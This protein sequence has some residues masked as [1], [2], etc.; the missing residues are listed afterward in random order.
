M[1]TRPRTALQSTRWL[2]GL[3]VPVGQVYIVAYLDVDESRSQSPASGDLGVGLSS[4][5]SS[6]EL[7][8]TTPATFDI[9]MN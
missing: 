9:V 6:V 1:S 3:P 5:Q 4:E 2:E 8:K 7:S